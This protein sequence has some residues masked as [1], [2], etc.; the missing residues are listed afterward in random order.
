MTTVGPVRLV[1]ALVST[2]MGILN[3][4]A[5][6]VLYLLIVHTFSLTE[7]VKRRTVLF[8]HNYNY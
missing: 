1:D 7:T 4:H 5:Q 3:S 6:A 8:I 2:V